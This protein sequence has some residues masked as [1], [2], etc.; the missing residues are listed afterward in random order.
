MLWMEHYAWMMFELT[1]W[2][3]TTWQLTTFSYAYVFTTIL[4]WQMLVEFSFYLANSVRGS[5]HLD[6]YCTGHISLFPPTDAW[7]HWINTIHTLYTWT[8][9]SCLPQPLTTWRKDAAFQHHWQ[10]EWWIDPS[11]LALCY[12]HDNNQWTVQYPY[13]WQQMYIWISSWKSQS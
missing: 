1:F 7:K 4:K 13:I 10:W 6:Q 9:S 8:S 11:T 3:A 5:T 12:N 2:Q